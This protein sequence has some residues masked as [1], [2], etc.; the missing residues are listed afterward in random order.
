MVESRRS[1]T[2]WMGWPGAPLQGRIFTLIAYLVLAVL[3][4]ALCLFVTPPF[5]VPDEPQ[6]FMRAYE[7]SEGRIWSVAEDGRAGAEV[8]ASL[9]SFVGRYPAPDPEARPSFRPSPQ[10]PQAMAFAAFPRSSFY[11]PLSFAPQAAGIWLARQLGGGYPAQFAAARAVNVSAALCLAAL[12]LAQ[13]PQIALIL[14][15]LALLPMTVFEVS[16][17]SPDATLITGALCY[18]ACCHRALT[19]GRWRAASILLATVSAVTLVGLKPVY[20][21]V[22]LYPFVPAALTREGRRHVLP[23]AAII[24][25]LAVLASVAWIVS[26][27]AGV[28]LQHAG[29][30]PPKQLHFLA[31]H[32][33]SFPLI[34]LRTLLVKSK[35]YYVTLVGKLG[36]NHY[37][38][39]K[40]AYVT[41]GGT[42]GCA[43][44][45]SFTRSSRWPTALLWRGLIVVASIAMIYI[46]LYVAWT[47]P[48]AH[49]VDGVQGRYLVPPLLVALVAISEVARPPPDRLRSTLV[50]VTWAGIVLDLAFMAAT[51]HG[52]YQHP[53]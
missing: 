27:K 7:I 23:A 47:P 24:L 53:H 31:S 29:A 16:S 4:S 46:T 9:A 52:A 51:L 19:D 33:A 18:V 22:L 25:S 14:A 8:P 35:H 15:A 28:R 43:V 32:L 11:F 48:G 41:A 2:H 34:A 44:L 42:I 13:A 38:L 39:F 17:V 36:W 12:A 40:L 49:T 10:S 50:A 5:Q 21:P 30:D 20:A 1:L 3:A 26:S 6:H 37:K 45:A